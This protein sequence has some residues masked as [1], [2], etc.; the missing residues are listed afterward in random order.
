V[1]EASKMKESDFEASDFSLIY[2]MEE[3]MT[4]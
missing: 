1:V 3:K 2:E 4:D